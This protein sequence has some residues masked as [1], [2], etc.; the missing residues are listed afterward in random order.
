LDDTGVKTTYAILFS[1]LLVLAQTALPGTTAAKA[2]PQ[3]AHCDCGMKECCLNPSLPDSTP[4]P[5]T[6]ALN[7]SLKHFQLSVAFAA[8]VL[9]LQVSATP[10]IFSPSSAAT[11]STA[12]PLYE[13]NCAWLI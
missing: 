3:C 10:Q 5:A 13:R 11:C 6:P 8:A 7:F 9:V 1:V 12:A 2:S 4:G